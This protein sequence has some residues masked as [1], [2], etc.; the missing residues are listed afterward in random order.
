MKTARR[1]SGSALGEQLIALALLTLFFGLLAVAYSRS[2]AF[3]MVFTVL[4]L[5]GAA[6]AVGYG[7]HRDRRRV[8]ELRARCLGAIDQAGA[9]EQALIETAFV[10]AG[11]GAAFGLAGAAGR[12]YFAHGFQSVQVDRIVLDQVSAAFA[13]SDG[14]RGFRLEVRVRPERGGERPPARW[15][16]TASREEARRWVSALA[17]YLG[18][19]V[20]WVEDS[21]PQPEPGSR[22]P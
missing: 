2:L 11:A 12:I 16:R 14:Q 8:R 13:R 6:L 10:D 18:P 7:V 1:R 15:L 20:S 4:S 19:R 17:P 9:A 5:A 21:N 3:G 22:Q